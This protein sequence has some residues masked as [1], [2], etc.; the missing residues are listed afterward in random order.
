M[1]VE[2]LEE[3]NEAPS[4]LYKEA[5]QHLNDGV[6]IISSNGEIRFANTTFLKMSGFL[7]KRVVGKNFNKLLNLCA[8]PTENWQGVV[9]INGETFVVLINP[10]KNNFGKVTN[11]IVTFSSFHKN[12]LDPLTKLP[13][14][15]LLQKKLKEILH[16]SK[17]NDKRFAVLY[18]DLDRFK[19]VNDTL[20]HSYGD[21]L[22]QQASQR[23]KKQIANEHILARM[24]GDEFVCILQDL[25][26]ETEAEHIAQM[27]I[28]DFSKPFVLCEIE[29]HIS[30]SIGISLFPFDGDDEEVLLTNADS[31]MYRAKKKGR[32]QYEKAKVEVNAGAFERL[33]IENYLRKALENDE[34]SL[35]FQPQLDIKS[36]KIIGFE[37]LLRWYHPDLGNIPPSDFIPIAED[38]GL[39][40][41]IGDWVL[42]QACLQVKEWEKVGF[43]SLRV[44]VNLSAQQFLQRNMVEK[45]K[46]VIKETSI[47]PQNLEL[48]ITERV[49]IHDID[50][51]LSV[52]K[53][54]KD[55]GVHI[56]IDDFGTGYSSLNYLK[57]LPI[58]TLKIDR[59]F[60]FDIDTNPS[61]K[62][63]TSAITSMAHDLNLNVIAEGVETY[64]QLSY[65]KKSACDAI[66]G[67]YFSKPLQA[68]AVIE[69]LLNNKKKK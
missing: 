58:H 33:S 28:S 55:I 49:V 10:I 17:K 43:H 51:A 1:V 16:I 22:L 7:K 44:A 6:L 5:L 4:N 23:L 62:A 14:R 25:Q 8:K 46:E 53:Q 26:N 19:F 52:L 29:I 60:I 34:F 56:S 32:N 68:N 50:S 41:P 63:L 38:T 24:G 12:G 9:D 18:I 66:Q 35:H 42:R 47:R 31:A 11:A 45:I 21:L 3:R 57:R 40:L 27:I 13:N 69:F 65:V 37:A 59:S 64:D 15:Y 67:F 30:A 36:E 48:E 54:L 20:G 39:I 2:K 61:S